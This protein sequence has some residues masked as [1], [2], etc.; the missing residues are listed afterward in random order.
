[1]LHTLGCDPRIRSARNTL[2]NIHTDA[3]ELII[4][5]HDVEALAQLG[6]RPRLLNLGLDFANAGPSADLRPPRRVASIGSLPGV[7]ATY[8]FNEPRR[9]RGI[10]NGIYTGQCCEITIPCWSE[11]DKNTFARFHPDNAAGG[12]FG[13]CNLAGVATESYVTTRDIASLANIPTNTTMTKFIRRPTTITEVRLDL[14]G[15]AAA[16]GLEVRA[17]NRIID[18]N[19]SPSPECRRSNHRH[20]PVG[21]GLMGV[22]DVL[23]RLRVAWGSRS[24]R[25]VARGIAAAIYFGAMSES[26]ALA[27][28]EGPYATFPGSPI[29]QGILQPD[30]WVRNGYLDP[31]WEKEVEVVTD[32]FLKAAESATLRARCRCGL[33]NVFVTAYM[34]TATTSNI[35]GQNECFEPFTTNLYTRKTLAGEFFIV[36]RHLVAELIE[37][38]LWDDTL[39]CEIIAAGGSIQNILRIPADV[40]YR[41]RTAREIHQ[42]RFI[43][44]AKAMSPFI[45]QSMSLNMYGDAPNL[46]K[47]LRFLIE[48][49]DAGLKTGVYYIHAKPAAGAQKMTV[50]DDDQYPDGYP[51]ED[52]T[53]EDVVAEIGI[54]IETAAETCSRVNREA[55]VSCSL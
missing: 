45:C 9:H 40:R 6:F 35:A 12:E 16:A 15:I 19:Y 55:C 30:L 50:Q 21:V 26:A 53:R 52:N 27:E 41:N 34:P 32:G 49:W 29:S 43:W 11:F 47:I 42:S 14:A 10:F 39:R 44:M 48:A 8:C 5:T 20:R 3:H 1:M 25:A 36:N 13:V 2:Q 17:L 46:P 22:A 54:T 4:S 33:R 37:L 24:G 23:A 28:I 31:N 18:I 38:G 51:R 7:H